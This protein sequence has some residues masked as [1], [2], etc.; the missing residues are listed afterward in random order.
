MNE[1]QAKHNLNATTARETTT[2]AATIARAK[3]TL[4]AEK[5]RAKTTT[6]FTT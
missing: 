2:T 3:T 1:I 5:A 4:T 6:T